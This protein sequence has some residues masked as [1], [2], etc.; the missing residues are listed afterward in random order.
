MFQNPHNCDKSKLVYQN[1]GICFFPISYFPSIFQPNQLQWDTLMSHTN[2]VGAERA[3]GHV[4][5]AAA[6]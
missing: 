4:H 6:A 3:M 2:L 5:A 1:S